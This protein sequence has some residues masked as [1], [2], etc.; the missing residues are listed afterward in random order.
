MAKQISSPVPSPA[1]VTGIQDP[2][3]RRAIQGLIDT[4][5]TRNGQTSERFLTEADIKQLAGTIVYQGLGGGGGGGVGGGGGDG[6]PDGGYGLIRDAIFSTELWRK[7]S[8]EIEW[9]TSANSL[10][11]AKISSL[12]NG[13]NSERIEIQNGN[14][15]L[16]QET[17][18]L[19]ASIGNNTAAILE[20]QTARVTDN[21]ALVNVINTMWASVGVNNALIQDGN[22]LAVNW[23]AAQAEKWTQMQVEVFGAD[24]TPIRAALAQEASLRV[25]LEG[26]IQSTW[27]VRMNADGRWAGFGLG[28]EGQPGSVVSTFI[29]AADQFGLVIPGGG[30]TPRMPFAVDGTGVYFNGRVNFSNVDGAGDLASKDSL[31]YTE[32]GGTKPPTN[33]DRT[34]SNT[35]YDTSRVGGTTATTVRDNAAN[36]ASANTRVNDWIRPGTTSINGNKIWTGDAYVDTLQIKGNAVTSVAYN[37]GNGSAAVTVSAGQVGLAYVAIGSGVNAT[38]GSATVAV[39]GGGSSSALNVGAFGNGTIAFGG[40]IPAGQSRTIST[41]ISAGSGACTIAVTGR[42]R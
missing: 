28:M 23:N 34:S 3:V 29:I 37:Y 4:H 19:K 42:M 13:F 32:I 36:G 14:T 24:G 22:S 27:T 18:G 41:T 21:T 9:L 2:A 38:S 10:S 5:N 11:L 8:S 26:D 33:A 25:D 35:A 7:L 16:V 39:G 1:P 30:G 31:T 15:Y 6:G 40:F 12:E 17:R 20:E